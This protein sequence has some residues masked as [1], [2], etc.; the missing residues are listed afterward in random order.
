MRKTEIDEVWEAIELDASKQSRTGYLLRRASIDCNVDLFLGLKCPEGQRALILRAAVDAM[1]ANRILPETRGLH[2]FAGRLGDEAEGIASL[3]VQLREA[4]F[5]DT[6]FAFATILINRICVCGTAAQ[7]VAEL[8]SQLLRWQKFLDAR[9]DG[10]GEEAQRGLYGEL[11]V[12]RNLIAVTGAARLAAAWTGP[13]GS[14]QDFR[15]GGPLAIEVKTS[16]AREPQSVEINGERQLDDSHLAHLYLV[17]LSIERLPGS[18]EMLPQLVHRILDALKDHPIE[19]DAFEGA[20]LESG[21]LK[22]HEDRYRQ[23]GFAVRNER[24]FRVRA[25]FPRITEA[26]L[27]EGV[28][29]VE[30][31]VGLSGCSSFAVPFAEISAAVAGIPSS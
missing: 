19:Q 26:D 28:G 8:L 7:A 5:A 9:S 31:R 15:F 3:V 10:L 18:G 2:L 14:P 12:L 4:S 21:Y 25:G 17:S 23:H 16:I 1:P 29:Q 24:C 27:P 11:H 13:S 30:Y 6:F 22:V 20:L